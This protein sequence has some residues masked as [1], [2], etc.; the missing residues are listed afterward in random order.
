M[1]W[2]LSRKMTD[3]SPLFFFFARIGVAFSVDSDKKTTGYTDAGVALVRAFT[4]ITNDKNSAAKG[5]SF[6]TD[7]SWKL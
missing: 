4:F 5:L 2:H 6:I 7:V 1:T 3:F